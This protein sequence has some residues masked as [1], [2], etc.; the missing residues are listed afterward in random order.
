M[1]QPRAADDF[2]MIRAHME[3]LRRERKW[4]AVRNFASLRSAYRLTDLTV[5][6]AD[7]ASSISVPMRCSS[8]IC[9][10]SVATGGRTS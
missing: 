10:N 2:P 8:N 1:A 7:S 9:L 4:I 3:K 6:V 5:I